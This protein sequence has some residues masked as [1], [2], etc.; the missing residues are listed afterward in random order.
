MF[1]STGEGSTSDE[2]ERSFSL[3]TCSPRVGPLH[4]LSLLPRTT[5]CPPEKPSGSGPKPCQTRH[6]VGENG[7]SRVTGS[8][9]ST[10]PSM[11]VG[12]YLF[13]SSGSLPFSGRT[14]GSREDKE[15]PQNSHV[16]SGDSEGEERPPGPRRHPLPRE[17]Q[18][19]GTSVRRKMSR[20]GER[21]DPTLHVRYYPK[22]FTQPFFL[23][24]GISQ[25]RG[26]S[27]A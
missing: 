6:T 2:L 21:E 18:K 23:N 24:G 27:R 17:P 25:S 7:D 19:T 13:I 26:S 11:E 14:L 9:Y 1:Q 16:I 12:G 3:S 4:L 22:T 5:S 15:R 20:R 8:T 10:L